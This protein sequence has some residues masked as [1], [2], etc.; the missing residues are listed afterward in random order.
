ML[1]ICQVHREFDPRCRNAQ[2]GCTQCSQGWVRCN[3]LGCEGFGGAPQ[4]EVKKL[5]EEERQLRAQPA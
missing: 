1:R 5:L 4:A 3:S 2:R